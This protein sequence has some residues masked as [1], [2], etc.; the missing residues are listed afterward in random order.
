MEVFSIDIHRKKNHV[1][2]QY[3]SC[4]SPVRNYVEMHFLAIWRPEF[5]Q[6]FICC[7]PRGYHK[8]TELSKL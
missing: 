5:E 7:P 4:A 6:F 8:E 1:H 2:Q 3:T